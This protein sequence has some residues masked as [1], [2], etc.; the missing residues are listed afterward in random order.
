MTR[1]WFVHSSP[2]W[3]VTCQCLL[4][5]P[6][7][8]RRAGRWQ[9]GKSCWVPWGESC[10]NC[11]LTPCMCVCLEG[12]LVAALTVEIPCD[13]EVWFLRA[14]L[15]S[16]LLNNLWSFSLTIWGYCCEALELRGLDIPVLNSLLDHIWCL[17][18]PRCFPNVHPMV[19]SDLEWKRLNKLCAWVWFN[20]MSFSCSHL[21]MTLCCS[22]Y[23]QRVNSAERKAVGSKSASGVTFHFLIASN[24][25]IRMLPFC[26]EETRMLKHRSQWY[27]G[28]ERLRQVLVLLP[29]SILSDLRLRSLYDRS[30]LVFSI[31]SLHVFMLSQTRNLR[32]RYSSFDR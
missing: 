16:F 15:T 4:Q 29:I 11:L 26:K 31:S 30:P 24:E 23:L 25:S 2:P 5:C 6:M 19:R 14:V 13:I 27:Q 3:G 21:T 12:T 10:P 28:N 18:A 8:S 9:Q 17:E 1:G 20:S 7:G 22:S 32:Q